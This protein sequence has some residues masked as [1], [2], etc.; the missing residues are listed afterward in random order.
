M[1][2]TTHDIFGDGGGAQPAT[3]G[4]YALPPSGHRLPDATQLG[5][6]VLQVADLARSLDYYEHV[7]GLRVVDRDASR[8]VLG[9]ARLG[10][11]ADRAARAAGRPGGTAARGIR[12]LSLRDSTPGP[13]VARPV[14]ASSRRD[15]RSRRRRRSSGER[16]V[17]SPGSRQSRNRGVRRPPA[18]ELAPHRPRADD[19]DDPVDVAGPDRGGGR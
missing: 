3:P 11:R 19:G 8:A 2:E 14:R 13:P 18:R 12:T 5:R 7:L 10:P 9:A 1:G 15:R 17:L 4:S 16:S 6:V